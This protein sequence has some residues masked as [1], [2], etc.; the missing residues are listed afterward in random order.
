[1]ARALLIAVSLALLAAVSLPALAGNDLVPGEFKL[2]EPTL[3]SLGFRW[4]VSG[5]DDKDADAKVEYRLQG[6]TVWSLG[7]PML[8]IH[9]EP[10]GR[11]GFVCG[12]L[13]AGS[14]LNLNPGV[15]YEVRVTLSD[16]DGITGTATTTFTQMT[17]SEPVRTR[18]TTTRHVYTSCVGADKLTPCYSDIMTAAQA[19]QPGEVVF[20]HAGTYVRTQAIDLRSLS[21]RATSETNPITF[22]GE[23]RALVVFDA[24]VSPSRS[25]S[26]GYFLVGGTKWLTF[27][28]FTVKNAGTVF[29]GAEALGLTV[30]GIKMDAVYAGV[31]G[32]ASPS[33]KDAKWVIADNDIVGWNSQWY[34]YADQ[35]YSISHTGIRVYG[36]GHVVEHNR[37]GKFWDCIAHSDTG[38]G[39]VTNAT[40]DWRNPPSLNIDVAENELYE[41][42]DDALSSDYNFHNIRFL[43]NRMT[44]AHTALSSQPQYGG[45]AYFIRNVAYNMASNSFKF[46][47]QPA[48]LEAFHN[49]LVVH[50]FSWESDAGWL[51]AQV[52]NNVAVANP[53]SADLQVYTGAATHPRNRMDHNAYTGSTGS[54]LIKWN[55]APYLGSD[56]RN[57]V[58]LP[59]FYAGEGF[60]QHGKEV[61]YSIFQSASY[62]AGEGRTYATSEYDLRLRTAASA[63]DAAKPLPG[64]NDGYAG[65]APDM[66]AYEFGSA[67]PVYGPRPGAVTLPG[68]ASDVQHAGAPFTMRREGTQYRLTWSAPKT[69]GPVEQYALYQSPLPG[70]FRA[71]C[72]QNLGSG[73]SAL[74]PTLP[75]NTMFVVGA[76]NAAGEGS[77][78]KTSAGAERAPAY[79]PNLCP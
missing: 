45:P 33:A 53:S 27:E 51:N 64:I 38:G 16:P 58:D 77:L 30:R 74:L 15:S 14:V 71:A 25:N 23:G 22:R 39:Q 1:M 73:T 48:G 31:G 4:I 32:G 37:V 7:H 65:S 68:E 55:R 61:D 43:R 57:Y 11:D 44:N 6:D 62:P 29:S 59:A 2:D 10:A 36:K 67:L 54:R 66:G 19:A 78:G 79:G 9:S 69:G 46:H 5:D 63:V 56:W 18:G 26:A 17:R 42:F 13:F 52:Y 35:S 34:P 41:C 50:D 49:T 60:E 12:N 21:S 28:R 8:R 75:N 76:R 40:V 20:I 72:N 24:G 47:N 70:S 3:H